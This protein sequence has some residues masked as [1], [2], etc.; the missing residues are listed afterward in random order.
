MAHYILLDRICYFIGSSYV[1]YNITKYKYDLDQSQY[2][3]MD[4]YSSKKKSF[5]KNSS[6]K[7]QECFTEIFSI[8]MLQHYIINVI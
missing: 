4:S 6:R 8:C 5:K 2:K 7:F 3:N 1:C